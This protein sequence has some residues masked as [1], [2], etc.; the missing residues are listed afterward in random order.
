MAR[1]R[2]CW[3][4]Q[5]RCGGHLQ[6]PHSG[7]GWVPESNG[8]APDLILTSGEHRNTPDV[9]PG[10]DRFA[11]PWESG[12]MAKNDCNQHIKWFSKWR[13]PFWGW[14]LIWNTFP[15]SPDQPADIVL[16]AD[17]R[18][19]TPRS[20]TTDGESFLI[21]GDHNAQGQSSQ[22]GNWLWTYFPT[23]SHQPIDGFMTEDMARGWQAGDVT[24]NGDLIMIGNGIHVW[25]G[26]PESD[27]S[28]PIFTL[29]GLDWE[30]RGGDGS[31]VAVAGDIVYVSDYNT[32][33]VIGF[34]QAPIGVNS[35]PDFVLGAPDLQTNTLNE[36]HF[37]SNGIPLLLDSGEFIIGDGL[38]TR[39]NCWNTTPTTSGQPP[40]IVIDFQDEVVALAAHEGT[41]IA[42]GR[43]GRH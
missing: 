31:T 8:A 36:H 40:D 32:N 20:I 3:R 35:I 28:E 23:E 38:N 27:Q 41:V 13:H 19:G 24:T 25:D 37:I 7:M 29:D 5:V 18:M 9:E 11:W 1:G 4:G 34:N 22:T 39:L 12:P 30:L 2:R 15:T 21:I 14:V 26:I 10:V 43:M 16:S 42:G 33:R 6:P 17:R